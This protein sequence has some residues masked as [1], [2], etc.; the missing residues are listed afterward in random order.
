[1]RN[2]KQIEGV[3]DELLARREILRRGVAL[4][5]ASSIFEDL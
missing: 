2:R 5:G 4:A 1:M 3:G